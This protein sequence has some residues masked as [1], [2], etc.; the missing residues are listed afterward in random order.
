MILIVDDHADTRHV[1]ARLLRHN[2]HAAETAADGAAALE[3]M[4]SA[5][6]DLVLL[7]YNMPGMTGLDVLQ[8]IRATPELAD[9]PV[10]M[11]TAMTGEDVME[12]ARRLGVQGFVRKGA[13]DWAGFVA[14]MRPYLPVPA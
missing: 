10:I 2:G 4:K 11:F 13:I 1:M 6:P 9:L 8:E 14:T 7:D 3:A 5:R 12:G